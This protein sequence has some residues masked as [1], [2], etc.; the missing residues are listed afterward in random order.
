MSSISDDL[1]MKDRNDDFGFKSRVTDKD[2][3][4]KDSNTNYGHKPGLKGFR[5]LQ[6]K[7]KA[8]MGNGQCPEKSIIHPLPEEVV[9]LYNTDNSSSNFQK[10]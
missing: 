1:K 4:T 6:L 10:N 7:S 2:S 5:N 3:Q 9:P 8:T